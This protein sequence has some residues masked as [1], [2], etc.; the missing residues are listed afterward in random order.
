MQTFHADLTQ[1][2]KTHS[3]QFPS[4]TTKLDRYVWNFFWGQIGF[5]FSTILPAQIQICHCRCGKVRRVS[6]LSR[7]A[8]GIHYGKPV[9]CFHCLFQQL[10]Y[11]IIWNM[12]ISG[13]LAICREVADM[14]AV[15][16]VRMQSCVSMCVCVRSYVSMCSH[17]CLCAVMRVCIWSVYL[18]SLSDCVKRPSLPVVY[19]LGPYGLSEG[20]GPHWVL[21]FLQQ[22]SNWRPELMEIE[23]QA[24]QVWSPDTVYQLLKVF[25]SL[26][27]NN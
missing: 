11:L 2:W 12:R 9:S 23:D 25:T 5:S 14:C 15:M 21:L 26:Y 1:K 8:H 27:T 16:C 20:P 18:R 4:G 19:P 10:S 13:L 3:S 24:K 6:F 17:V 22:V 7:R